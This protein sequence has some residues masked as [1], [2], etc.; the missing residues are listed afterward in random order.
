[1]ETHYQISDKGQWKDVTL[2]EKNGQWKFRM[3]KKTL[4]LEPLLVKPPLYTFLV[5]GK[6]ILELEIHFEQNGEQVAVNLGHYPYRFHLVDPSRVALEKDGSGSG[7]GSGVISAP[8]PGKVVE[9]KVKVGD[10]VKAGQGVIVVE[11]MKMQ[12]ELNAES[13]GI[14]AEINVSAGQ[15]VEGGQTLV[16]I[17]A[18]S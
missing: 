6:D 15:T 13:A 9:I 18:E 7:K 2:V 12:N 4:S 11:A 3:G 8:M 1:M 17:Q 16:I 10:E 14:V 5:G